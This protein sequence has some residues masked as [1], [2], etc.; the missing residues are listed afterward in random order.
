MYDLAVMSMFKSK[1]DLCEP[2]KDLLL[3]EVVFG[4]LRFS[5]VARLQIWNLFRKV[6]TVGVIHDDAELTLLRLIDLLEADNV[7][8]CESFK[9]LSFTEGALSVI[10][11][12][13]L[14]VNLFDDCIWLHIEKLC[15]LGV[16]KAS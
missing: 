8:M 3:G 1:A 15:K 7:R 2:V 13:F 16:N 6:T 12:H 11:A 4:Y 5:L 9:D 10:F 14:N